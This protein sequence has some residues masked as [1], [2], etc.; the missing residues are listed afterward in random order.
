MESSRDS[1]VGACLTWNISNVGAVADPLAA[2]L[3]R[4]ARGRRPAHD[5]ALRHAPRRRSFPAGAA[6]DRVGSRRVALARDR[7]WCR[8]QRDPA[9]RR[10]AS[11]SRSSAALVVGVGTGA[12]FVAGLDLVRA[13][14]GRRRWQGAYGGATMAGGGLAL[15]V[16][17]QLD[18]D[19]TAGAR[20]TGAGLV[21]SPSRARAARPRRRRAFRASATHG[22]AGASATVGCSHSACC[23][24]RRSGSRSS[25]GT[26]SCRCSS[27][28]G[29]RSAAA[30]LAG[31]LDPLRRHRHPPA[32]RARC[33]SDA[34]SG[35]GGS[36]SPRLARDVGWELLVLALGSVA[37]RRRG[38]R[39]SC[40]G[41]RAG[42]P[43]AVDLRGGA[44][45]APGRA[46]GGDRARQRLRRARD[47]RRHAARR[48]RVRAARRRA[49]RVRRDRP[50]LGAA[51]LLAA[52]RGAGSR[53]DNHRFPNERRRI[54]D[55]PE[56]RRHRPARP[57]LQPPRRADAARASDTASS[58]AGR[59]T[60]TSSGRS[61]SRS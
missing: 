14:G 61:R 8:R 26:G 56:L 38:R 3:R 1:R 27:A 45:A 15:M 30:G 35:H 4:L 6:I 58:T 59:T 36:S 42:L 31:G 9:R 17:P 5:G 50:A 33:A 47:R 25:R 60:R 29:A 7:G 13:G 18:G 22:A 34:V 53:I 12:G 55:G 52:S 40:S 23:R 43:F 37:R 48:S 54:R 19:A 32:R 21:V 20:R 10:V 41:S 46:R 57:A 11:G 49:A 39:R 2:A 28:Q 44:A 24:R 51:A 16:V